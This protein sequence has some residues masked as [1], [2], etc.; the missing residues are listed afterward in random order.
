M[1]DE[2][3]VPPFD[4]SAA[5]APELYEPLVSGNLAAE[6]L[7]LA[8]Q[9]NRVF[10]Q[11]V[12]PAL[13]DLL[14]LPVQLIPRET[15]QATVA[16]ALNDYSVGDHF[17]PLELSPVSGS[18]FIAFSP[19]LMFLVLDILLATPDERRINAG[20]TVTAIELHILRELFDLIAR[21]VRA[22]WKEFYPLA[23]WPVHASGD[24]LE[25]LIKATANDPAIV[26][27]V[28]VELNGV[29]A[30]FRVILPTCLFRMAELK[31]Q[32]L[33]PP[34]TNPPAM[35]KIIFNRLGD[36]QLDL[37]LMLRGMSIRIRDL[38]DLTPGR[39]LMLGPSPGPPFEC[40]VNGTLQFTGDL[41]SNDGKYELQ[42]ETAS[43][44]PSGA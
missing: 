33:A 29:S 3:Q 22:S 18:G 8:H 42:I 36:A 28:S 14:Q 34:Q 40:L 32:V 37:E 27:S 11:A 19:P 16:Q 31:L 38:L 9:I 7:A 21:A 24:E 15:S 23:L 10:L 20:R 1:P 26:F 30:N 17:V 25:G 41:G 43:P 2:P 4:S 13:V 39:I 5:P 12:E 35:D 44:E 6:T